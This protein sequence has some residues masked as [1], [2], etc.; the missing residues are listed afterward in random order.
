MAGGEG[1]RLRPMTAN[2]PKPLLPVVNRPIMEHVLRLLKRHGITETV[3]TV[4]F[5][6]ALVRNYFGDGD[7]LGMRLEY[8]TEDIPLG[9]AGSVKN[10]ADRL[11]DAPFLV[12]SGDALT[13]IDL[14]DMIRFHRE[15]S[16]L[17]T[18]GLKRVPNPLEFGIII[19]D[20]LGRVQR[21]LE[22]PTWGQ[23]FSDT[24]NTGIYIMEPE[25][26]NEVA[27]GESVDWASD[28][29]PALLERGAPI[30]GYVADGY[31]E[32]VGTH[33][34]YLKAQADALS[35]EVRLDIGGFE[36]SPGVWVAASA[37][38]EP[39]AVLKGPLFIGEYA[40]VEGG[41]ELREYT[42]LGNN[43]VVREGAF[44]HRAIVH[45]NVYLG[46][47]AHLRGCVIGKST[48]VM[49]G[50]R[51][52]ENAV[53]GDEC[54]IEA[55]AYVSSGV[56]VYPFKTI[57]AGAVVNTSVIWESRG[58]RSLFGRR[59]VSGL[60]NVE[61]TPELCVRLASAYATTLKKGERV[62]TSRDASLAARAL[63]RAVISALTA[64][65][66]NVLD[67]EAAPLPVARFHSSRGTAAGG[68][69]LRTTAGDPQSVDI[70]IMDDRGADLPPAAQR[71]LERVFSRQEF[72]RAFPG[73]IAELTYPSRTVEDY[74]YELLRR[75]DMTGV[76]DM[77][78]VVDCAGGTSSL[79]LPRLLGRAGI[80]VLTVN[81]VLDDLSPT[82]TLAERRR[83][84]QRLS[85]LV[86]SSRASF[87]VRFDPVGE[88]V[89]LVDEMGQFISEER[90]LLVVLDLVAAE[91]RG[92]RVALPVTT[93]RVAEQVCRFHGVEVQ[94]T[95]TAVDALTSAAG[96][97]GMIFAGDG[98]GG[99]V[100]PEF[101]PAL[102]GLAA[103][104]RLLGLVARTRLSLSQIDA[105]IPEAKLLKRAIPTQWKAKGAVM[106]SVIEAAES[107]AEGYHIDTTDGVRVVG[108]DGSWVLILPAAT[109]PVTDLW[110]EA[111]D[112][113]SAQLLLERWAAVVEQAAL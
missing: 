85:E 79:V 53:I 66:I 33:E 38:V 23:V 5:L 39:D 105:R 84:L 26:L 55:E 93:T 109:E 89:A 100:V 25:V 77:K 20:E 72:R 48:D 70:V 40:K 45:S 99:F 60:V 6:A 65:A 46:P 13:D 31:W 44:L 14:T 95:S 58:Q 1:T 112:V 62:V 27:A 16:A 12:I 64:S 110:A 8:A 57:E 34:S 17:V 4:Q 104:M 80:E 101:S 24:V 106:R 52:E 102:D 107:A 11:H 87:G 42:V 96:G 68:I 86:S 49:R 94:W 76:R 108:D 97:P 98:R 111:S 59:G 30:Y 36:L 83:D 103:F 41:A 37:S 29:F 56:R 2:Q 32:D 18:I 91:R 3:V 75:V 113:D 63:K 35:G 90:A 81:A 73:E 67:L 82:E 69:A 61:I 15:N 22:K 9:T 51:I 54:V 21:F 88:R 78:V 50:A 7:E 92:G 28:V 10:A 71:K 47:G 19:V 43:A 74:T